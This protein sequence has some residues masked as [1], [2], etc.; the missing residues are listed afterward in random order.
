MEFDRGGWNDF[1]LNK[2]QTLEI[3]QITENGKPTVEVALVWFTGDRDV[4]AKISGLTMRGDDLVGGYAFVWGDKASAQA[5]YTVDIRT[6][7]V[8]PGFRGACRDIKP[9]SY[10]PSH[11]P[12]VSGKLK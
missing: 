5:A 4:K 2:S 3:T 7:D 9:F 10:P 8:I 12:I 11:A 6:G 1:V